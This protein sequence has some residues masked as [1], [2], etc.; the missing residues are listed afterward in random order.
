MQTKRL[1]GQ[2]TLINKGRGIRIAAAVPGDVYSHLLSAGQIPDP[3][4]RDNE[5]E[6][7]WI[8]ESDWV[9]CRSFAVSKG[10]LANPHVLLRAEWLDTFARIL[11]NGTLVAYTDNM[12]R[13]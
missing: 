4:Y 7:Q 12:F 9:Y 5:S 8:G 2:W 10:L 6:L 11:L 13:T 3:C 1:N